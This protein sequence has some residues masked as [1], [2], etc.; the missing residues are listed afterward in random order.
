MTRRV[1]VLG[2]S[3]QIGMPLC[4]HLEDIGHTVTGI[5]LSMGADHDLRIAHNPVLARRLEQADYVFFLAFDVGGARYLAEHGRTVEFVHGNTA[6]MLHTFAALE[7]WGGP[8]TFASS[9][10]SLLPHTPYGALKAVGERFTH[11]QR[12]TV[13]RLWNVYGREPDS[14]RAHVVSDFARM[15][16]ERGVI[17]MR[18]AGSEVRDFVHADDC[19]RG[20]ALVMD[21]HPGAGPDQPLCLASGTWT[22]VREVADTV[23]ALVDARVEAGTAADAFA[24]SY[25]WA[26]TLGDIPGWAPRIALV[27]GVSRVIDGIVQER[28]AAS[29]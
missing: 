29:T 6:L 1:L 9:Q 5:D 14:A 13:V 18:T 26:P 15:A 24:E 7:R 25:C 19:A 23:A 27:D 28:A 17:A 8:F 20:L 11:A 21:Q 12:G 3:G 2:S 16:L 4:R 10:M 22:T